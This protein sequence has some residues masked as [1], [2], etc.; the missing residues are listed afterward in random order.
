MIRRD[1]RY[2]TMTPTQ[3]LGEILHQELVDQ[4]V[5]KSLTLK[6]GKSLALN[7]SSSEVVE[8]KPKPSKS[9]KEDTSNEGSTD[10]ETAF[11]IRKYKKFLTSRASRK[12]GDERKKKSQRKC[13][14]CGEYG[15]FIAKCPKNKNKNEEE[16]KFKERSKEYKNKYQERAHV[17]QQWDSSDEDEEPKKQGMAT[18]AMAQG[19]SSPRLFNNLSDDEDHSH[20]CLMARGSKVQES[21]TSSSPISSSST[22]SSDIENI[23]EEKEMEDNMIKKFDKKG[24]KEIKKLLDKLGKEG[25]P[26]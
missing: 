19:S 23:D 5:E 9:K 1:P 3:L 13:Y 10:E 26:P 6:M 2:P 24:H 15:H 4:D 21:T 18:V 16:K 20:F 17:G 22:P 7:A 25:D 8:A 12:G 14:E 11:A